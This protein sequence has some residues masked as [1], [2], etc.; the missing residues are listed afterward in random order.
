MYPL[1]KYD[2]IRNLTRHIKNREVTMEDV[3]MT[4]TVVGMVRDAIGPDIDL[5]VDVT[6][7]GSVGTMTRIGA[8]S[9]GIRPDVV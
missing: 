2:P 5:M 7:E 8:Q 9:G 1:S 6:A 4:H 3:K